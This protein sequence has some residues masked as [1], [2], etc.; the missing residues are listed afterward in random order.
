VCKDANISVSHCSCAAVQMR[1]IEQDLVVS[2]AHGRSESCYSTHGCVDSTQTTRIAALQTLDRAASMGHSSTAIYGVKQAPCGELALATN[3]SCSQTPSPP[4]HT[5]RATTAH[6]RGPHCNIV[7]K[8]AA[9]ISGA[10]ARAYSPWLRPRVLTATPQRVCNLE[11]GCWC[12]CM[13]VKYGD[14]RVRYSGLVKY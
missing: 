11:E 9:D 1:N 5:S 8:G 4:A 13:S 12:S 2:V 3:R 7:S 14:C 6:R 10:G